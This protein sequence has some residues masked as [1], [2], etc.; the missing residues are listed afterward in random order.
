MSC[1]IRKI[2]DGKAENFALLAADSWDLREQVEFFEKWLRDIDETLEDADSW[3]ADIGFSPR[4]RAT[5]G[6][7]VVSL[8]LMELCLRNKIEIFLSEYN[9]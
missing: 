3:I 9:E 2:V 5:G 8:E 1:W 6:G 4:S 7:P